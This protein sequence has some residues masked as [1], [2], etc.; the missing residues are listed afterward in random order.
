[1]KLKYNLLLFF[2][3]FN[4]YTFSQSKVDYYNYL[5]EANNCLLTNNLDSAIYV[6]ILAVEANP[7]SSASNFLL[8][9]LYF[10]QNNY[11]LALN[12]AENAYKIDTSNYWYKVLLFQI[13]SNIHNKKNSLKFL[14][15]IIV[16]SYNQNDFLNAFI[17][18]DSIKEYNTFLSFLNI[19]KNRF[20]VDDIYFNKI[21]DYYSNLDDSINTLFYSKL[22]FY[23][24]NFSI[25]SFSVLISNYMKYNFV[26]SCDFLFSNNSINFSSYSSYNLLKSEYFLNKFKV[27]SDSNLIDSSI[28]YFNNSLNCSDLDFNS[29]IKF[30]QNYYYIF[31]PLLLGNSFDSLANTLTLKFKYSIEIYAFLGDTY[32]YFN[33]F[34]D[35]LNFYKIYLKSD[36]SDF[37]YYFKTITLLFEFED[38]Y[39]LDSLTNV[40]LNYFPL[41]PEV[42]LYRGIALLNLNFLDD[43]LQNLEYGL[44]ITFDNN[45]LKAYFNFYLSEYYRIIAKYNKQQLFFDNSLE[46]CQNDNIIVSNFALYYAQH[47]ILLNKALDLIS[48][49]VI[50]NT[51]DLSPFISYVYSYVLFK[52][53]DLSNS[54]NYINYSILNSNFP[55][56]FYF[57]LKAEIL[58]SLNKIDESNYYYNLAYN[59][60]Y[61]QIK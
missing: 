9:K 39:T 32:S 48:S 15:S 35:A 42:Y 12:Y 3:L 45:Q 59:Y 47:N 20:G 60:G 1:M 28:Y 8:A 22:Y 2:L 50:T 11:I 26:D 37:N 41:S 24:Y 40:C 19:Y 36:F 5:I 13:N 61:I 18:T 34:F 27:L 16:S 57:Y 10:R 33:R 43:A 17:Y 23:N 6:S 30:L 21:I 55:N 25:N 44:D 29:T 51:D 53:D 7:F 49:C 38:W 54:L 56:F 31:N 52:I 14:N 4:I 46:I 58:K